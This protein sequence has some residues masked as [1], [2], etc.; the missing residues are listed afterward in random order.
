MNVL[1]T[2]GLGFIGSHVSQEF[3]KN[4]NVT[5]IDL[6]EKVSQ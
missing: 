3:S 2:G 6:P 5:I 4:A 1:V